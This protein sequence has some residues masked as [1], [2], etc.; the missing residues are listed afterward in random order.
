MS[1]CF[2]LRVSLSSLKTLSCRVPNLNLQGGQFT[3]DGIRQLAKYLRRHDWD[4]IRSLSLRACKLDP[5]ALAEAGEIVS[6]LETLDLSYNNLSGGDADVRNFAASLAAPADDKRI[7]FVDLRH[8][9][10]SDPCKRVLSDVGRKEK[11]EVKMW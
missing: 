11:I 3:A 10:L 6:G 7:R 2:H 8:C 5:A 1:F 4:R 9:R